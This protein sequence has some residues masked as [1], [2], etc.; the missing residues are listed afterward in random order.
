M[1]EPSKRELG[2]A[3]TGQSGPNGLNFIGI[4]HKIGSEPAISQLYSLQLYK[5]K[6]FR[7]WIHSH[8]VGVTPSK[9]DIDLKGQVKTQQTKNGLFTPKF[10]IYITNKKSKYYG[11]YINY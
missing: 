2:W 8:P 3:K 1:S 7:E 4:G 9:D 6:H 5:E 11:K 10:S